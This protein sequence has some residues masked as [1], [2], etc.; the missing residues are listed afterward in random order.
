MASANEGS[1][2]LALPFGSAVPEADLDEESVEGDPMSL[3]EILEDAF[4][5]T[6]WQKLRATKL[7]QLIQLDSSNPGLGMAYEKEAAVANS[8]SLDPNVI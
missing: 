7:P 4:Q 8:I 5:G 3:V 1:D 6:Q 2:A